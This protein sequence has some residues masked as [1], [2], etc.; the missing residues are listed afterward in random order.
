VSEAINFIWKLSILA[1]L[2]VAVRLLMQGLGGEYPALLAACCVLPVK[3]LL[4]M[5][6]YSWAASHDQARSVVVN[7][8]PIEW[9]LSTWIVFELFSRWTRSYVGIGRFGKYLMVTLLAIALL[10]SVAFWHAEWQ[11][12]D[13]RQNFRIYYILNRMVMLSLALFV[14]GTWMFFRNY[15][16][17]IAPNVARHTQVA[18]VYF[19]VTA[20]SELIFT[21]N[22]WKGPRVVGVINL[23]IVTAAAGCY[24]AWAIL[25]TRK[26]QVSPPAQQVSLADR[27]RIERLNEELLVFMGNVPKNGR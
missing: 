20:L 22:S 11:A 12:L 1:E 27:E 15:P 13:F 9:I 16:V 25:L 17:A 4:V 6:S 7:L 2:A 3:S 18:G 23:S 10:L 5:F 19:V 26:G 8:R 14:V 24:S 21:L